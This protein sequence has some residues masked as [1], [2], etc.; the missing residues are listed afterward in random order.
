MPTTRPRAGNY[1]AALT[2]IMT[3]E[4]Y[5]QSAVIARDHGGPFIEFAKN[6]EPFLRVIDKHREAAYQIPT[7]GVPA[8]LLEAVPPPLGRGVRARRAARLPQRADQPARAHR[9][10]RR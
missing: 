4:A 10:P 1:A 6:E 2:S 9:L 3:A 8:D 7:E 5:R